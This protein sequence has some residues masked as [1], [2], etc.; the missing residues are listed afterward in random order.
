MAARGDAEV[1]HLDL[2]AGR[3]QDVARLDVA[4]DHPALM[5]EAERGGHV[6]RDLGGAIGQDRAL[7][8]DDLSERAT[9]DVLHDDEVRAVLLA[10]VVDRDDVGV[11]EVGGGLCL[12][13]EALDE[14]AVGRQF[15]EEDLERDLPVEHEVVGQVD[16]GHATSRQVAQD[17]VPSAEHLGLLRH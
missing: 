15:G 14:V 11:A 8:A 7:A 5:G 2:P 3:D 13:A 12:A 10:P 6:G 16:L 4:V 9:L 17:L 1:G